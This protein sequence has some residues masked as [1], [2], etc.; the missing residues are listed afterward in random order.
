MKNK[1]TKYIGLLITIYKK[2]LGIRKI[3]FA[4][5]F[6]FFVAKSFDFGLN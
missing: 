2:F 4:I 6:Y 1:H 5:N 3:F